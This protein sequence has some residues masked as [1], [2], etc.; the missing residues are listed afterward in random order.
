MET[1]KP[2]KERKTSV[3][4]FLSRAAAFFEMDNE[5][6]GWWDRQSLPLMKNAIVV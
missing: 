1:G 3:N 6:S 2:E 4:C 5:R